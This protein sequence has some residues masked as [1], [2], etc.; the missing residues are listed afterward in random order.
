M[1]AKAFPERRGRIDIESVTMAIAAFQRSLISFDSSWDRYARGDRQA[2]SAAAER[3]AR[4]FNG[5]AGCATCHSGANFTDVR[6]HRLQL[7]GD[8]ED[9]GLEEKSH[10]LEDRGIP[11]A[12]AAQCGPD[13]ALSA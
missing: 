3:G 11:D 8:S 10:R 13:R 2:L 7:A 12:I 6:F 1:F 4:L 5:I 9:S